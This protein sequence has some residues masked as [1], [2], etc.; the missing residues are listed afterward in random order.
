MLEIRKGTTSRNYEN[1][2]FSEFVE[3][4]KNYFDKYSFN[5]L[6]AVNSV[7]KKTPNRRFTI[8]P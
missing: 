7:L 5:R 4:I 1:T 3:S 2:F 6:L 8:T